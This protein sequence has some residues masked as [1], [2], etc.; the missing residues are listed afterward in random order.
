MKKDEIQKLLDFYSKELKENILPFWMERCLDKKNGGYFNCFD[1]EGK[2]LISKDKYTWSM[3]R[4]I[5][6]FSTLASMKSSIF[7]AEEK[8]NFIKY[9]KSGVDFLEKNV[10][11]GENDWRCCF[12]LTEDGKH[13]AMTKGAPLDTSIY[14]DCFVVAGFAKYAYV[15][16]NKVYYDFAKKLYISILNRIEHNNYYTLPYPLSEGYRAHG[17][18]MILSNLTSEM[19]HSSNKFDKDYNTTLLK[20]LDGF[21]KDIMDHFCDKNLVIHEIITKDNSF[22]NNLFGN[23]ANPGHSV[24]D[25]WFMLDAFEILGNEDLALKAPKIVLKAFEN[26]WDKEMGGMLH[27]CAIDG[28]EPVGSCDGVENEPML[29]QVIKGW[30]DKLWWIHSESLYTSLRCYFFTGNEEFL[31]WHNKVNKYTFEHFP[32]PNKEIGEWIQILKRNGDPQ[33]KIVALPV[34]DPYHIMRNLIL[35]IELLEKQLEK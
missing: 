4:F 6:I 7:S 26:G 1:N 21:T 32:N 20:K 35:I 15:T 10:L 18:P 9:A 5:W 28:G 3:G 31:N 17:I 14:A 11:L 2:N 23:H 27:Y 19:I 25:M 33:D 24:E 13:K 29:Q 34:K 16:S 22:I 8:K 30:G 12:L